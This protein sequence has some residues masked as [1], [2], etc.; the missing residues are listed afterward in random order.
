MAAYVAELAELA[1]LAGSCPGRDPAASRVGRHRRVDPELT[2]HLVFLD[3]SEL[4]LG[5]ET[6]LGR[7]IGHAAGWLVE[8]CAASARPRPSGPPSRTRWISQGLAGNGRRR[9]ERA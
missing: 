2:V 3:Q 7:S 4:V 6:A 8:R 1:D 9:R 5:P